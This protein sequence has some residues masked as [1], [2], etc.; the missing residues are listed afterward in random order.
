MLE[1]ITNKGNGVYYYVDSITEGRRVFLEKLMG[2]LMTI[3]KDVKIQVEFNPAKVGQYRLIGYANRVLKKEDFN[4]DQ[5][6]CG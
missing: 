6:G 3:A 4:N 1:A 5:G 2:T